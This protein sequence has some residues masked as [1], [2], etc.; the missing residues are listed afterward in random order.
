MV[1]G[2]MRSPGIL[3][4]DR[5]VCGSHGTA[6]L[7]IPCLAVSSGEAL[8]PWVLTGMGEWEVASLGLVSLAFLVGDASPSCLL[9]RLASVF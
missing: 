1:P 5:R 4:V 6:S 3:C 9:G 8:I 7:L 2:A